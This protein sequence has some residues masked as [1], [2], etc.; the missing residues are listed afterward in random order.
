MD[1]LDEAFRLKVKYFTAWG[2]STENWKRADREVNF[3]MQL[4]RRSMDRFERKFLEKKIRFCHFGRKDRLPKTIAVRMAALEEKTKQF[5]AGAFGLAIDYG[6]RDEILRA[7][8]RLREEGGE[9][10]ERALS[11][12]MDTRDF[13][14]P[15]LVIRT[16][17]EQRT[18]GL[19]PWQSAYNEL[20]FAPEQIPDFGP[21]Q[22]RGALAEFS[23]RKRNFGA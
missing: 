5:T 6:G 12:A 4:F 11:Q 21:A 10:S 18:S 13:P 22:L 14:D 3:L 9:V 20:Y 17:G 16:S 8:S 15:D 19:M 23:R 1:L 2:F 7:V